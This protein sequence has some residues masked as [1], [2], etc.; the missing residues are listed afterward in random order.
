MLRVAVAVTTVQLSAIYS[1]IV[2]GDNVMFRHT[3]DANGALTLN[4]SASLIKSYLLPYYLQVTCGA[5]EQAQV[6][7]INGVFF[8]PKFSCISSYKLLQLLRLVTVGGD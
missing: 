8:E 1:E 5:G 4:D 3:G 6:I 2:L 7:K